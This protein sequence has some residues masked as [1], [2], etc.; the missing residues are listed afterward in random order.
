MPTVTVSPAQAR[1][2]GTLDDDSILAAIAE[3][4]AGGEARLDP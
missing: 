3:E 2:S 4:R 1:K